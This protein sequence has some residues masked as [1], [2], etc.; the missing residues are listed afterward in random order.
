M[1]A[2]TS[3]TFRS[4]D[5]AS[6]L[7]YLVRGRTQAMTA[8]SVCA[9]VSLKVPPVLYLS[10]AMIGVMALRYGAAE[11][12]V[13][14]A[15]SAALAAVF[16]WLVVDTAMPV[17]AFAV[18]T[19]VPVWLL[20]VVLRTTRSQGVMLATAGALGALVVVGTHLVLGNAVEWWRHLLEQLFVNGAQHAGLHMNAADTRRIG[21]MIRELAPMMT[22]LV[23]AATV[24]GLVLTVLIARWWHALLDNRGGFGREFRALALPRSVAV[25]ALIVVALGVLADRLTGG[26]ARDLVWT[27]LV[28]YFL[29]GLA[30]VHALIKARGRTVGWLVALY[31]LLLFVPLQMV[32]L[33]AVG[34]Y[35]EAWMN[36]RG[37]FSPAG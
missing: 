5:V 29:Q 31:A 6:F 18:A 25:V 35:V 15:G 26:V 22:G 21:A 4:S 13:T 8:S 2:T 32:V 34:G 9:V 27:V 14:V 19:W 24:F 16:T 12:L 30:L 33:V 17:L 28:L 11:G 1:R 37:R 36:F 7:E 20:A 23:A 3:G 10:G